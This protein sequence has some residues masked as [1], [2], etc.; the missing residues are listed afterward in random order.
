MQGWVKIYA[1]ELSDILNKH[2]DSSQTSAGCVQLQCIGVHVLTA[3]ILRN[4]NKQSFNS[5]Q[6]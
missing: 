2:D 4:I 3:I 1:Y 5:P 6:D